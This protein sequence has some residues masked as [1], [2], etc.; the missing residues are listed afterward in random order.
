[1]KTKMTATECQQYVRRGGPSSGG[2][3]DAM[4]RTRQEPCRKPVAE[5]SRYCPRHAEAA[6]LATDQARARLA[7]Q[8]ALLEKLA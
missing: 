8:K 2:G 3:Y 5:G 6:A 4:N 1:M 7:R